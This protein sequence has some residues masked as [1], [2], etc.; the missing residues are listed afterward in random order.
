MKRTYAFL[1]SV[2]IFSLFISAVLGYAVLEVYF[3]VQY[4]KKHVDN[5]SIV[6]DYELGWEANPSVEPLKNSSSERVVY[7][8]GDSFT[9]SRKWPLYT[10][11]E[12]VL[13]GTIFDGYSLGVSGYGITQTYLKLQKHFADKKPDVVVLL[14][15]AWNDMRDEYQYPSVFYNPERSTRPYF[16]KKKDSYILK[17]ARSP[18]PLRHSEVYVRIIQR[19][20]LRL[21]GMIAE[22]DVDFFVRWNM[23]LKL[24]YADPAA[25][26]P[27]YRSH[28]QDSRY[29]SE[30][31]EVLEH[32]L[33]SLRDYV[34]EQGATFLVVGIDNAF[35]VDHDVYE[36]HIDHPSTFDSDLPLRTLE[37]ISKKNNIRFLNALGPLRMLQKTLGHKIYNGP[38]GNISGHLEEE[39]EREIAK[40]VAREL[41]DIFSK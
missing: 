26:K 24:H 5:P 29:I 21:S 1:F 12:A 40:L 7:F 14:L 34:T 31:Y 36:R 28:Q 4:P 30:A 15:F 27:F 41:T 13:Q 18:S 11:E 22:Y 16:I 39:G 25:W 6:L 8:I 23:P 3:R 35:T 19:A 2:S 17:K 32:S 10:Q 9:D 38:P 37:Q 20:L 33:V